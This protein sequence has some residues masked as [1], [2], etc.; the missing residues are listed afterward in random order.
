M[1]LPLKFKVPRCLNS[2]AGSSTR[3]PSPPRLKEASR[4]TQWPKALAVSRRGVPAFSPEGFLGPARKYMQLYGV[5]A[6]AGGW[7]LGPV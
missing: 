7:A 1:L 2:G 6:P 4:F 5:T 3:A